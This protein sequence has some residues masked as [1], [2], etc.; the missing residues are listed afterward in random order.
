MKPFINNSSLASR[1]ASVSLV[2]IFLSV[3]SLSHADGTDLQIKE[4]K[5]Q[6]EKANSKIE[7]LTKR[8][9]AVEKQVAASGKMHAEQRE[10]APSE[11]VQP[12]KEGSER[13]HDL[14]IGT[15]LSD[16]TQDELKATGGVVGAVS[17]KVKDSITH[18]KTPESRLDIIAHHEADTTDKVRALAE[19][20][21]YFQ[22]GF[23]FHGYLRSG[24]GVNDKGGRQVAF[25]APGAGSK[26]RLGNEVETYGELLFT[27]NFLPEQKSPD[28]SVN[29]RLGFKTLQN[30]VSDPDNDEFSVK[31][32]YAEMGNFDW[33]PGAK[34]WAGERFYR[35]QDIYII[36]YYFL[37]MSGYGG[38]VQDVNLN[39]WGKLAFAYIAGANDSYDLENVGSVAKNSF[40]IRVYDFNVPFG[41]GE[42]W[43]DP[44]FLKGGSYVDSNGQDQN[45]N[46]AWGFAGGFIHTI[47]KP[48]NIDGYNKLSLQYG[49]GSSA[50]FSANVPDPDPKVQNRWTFQVTDAGVIRPWD[51]FAMMYTFLYKG[52]DNGDENDSRVDW[53]SAGARPMY[54]FNKHWALALEFGA[55][56]VN[57][58]V[59]HYNDT[60]YKI[61]LAPELRINNTFLGRP[62]LRA[63]VTY[64]TWGSDFKGRVGGAAYSDDT[65]GLGA[66]VQME[67]WW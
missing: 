16:K 47:K 34:F 65:S 9:E 44:S 21:H 50:D 6:L 66:G 13:A 30:N 62:V 52:T 55:D 28:F 57:S 53:F 19:K 10:K 23:E 51:D 31:E 18:G 24:A 12:D 63:Y 37:D 27:Q 35:R 38:G 33:A 26:Y 39:D 3:S 14:A 7:D 67:A 20:F 60:L 4:L 5:A 2:F 11:D 1:V 42:V 43:L 41:K 61:T 64:S 22:E 40:D 8:L 49:T 32:A 58:R 25:Q 15:I 45:Y 56:H 54:F 36:D 59:H 17:E 48:F 46:S 29:V